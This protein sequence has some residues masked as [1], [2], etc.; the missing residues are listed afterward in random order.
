MISRKYYHLL[1]HAAC[2]L[3]FLIL[4]VIIFLNF[5]SLQTSLLRALLNGPL[6]IMVFY[7]NLLVLIP[8]FYE[9]KHYV[10]YILASFGLLFLFFTLRV[11]IRD[12]IIGSPQTVLMTERPLQSEFMI[13]TSFIFVFGLSIFYKLAINHLNAAERNREIL[14]QRDEAELRMLKAQVNPHF[15]FNTLNNLYSLAYTRSEKTAGAIMS[16]SEIMRYLIYEAGASLVP[17]EREIRFLTNYVE[18]EKL[19]IEDSSKVKLK[20]INPPEDHLIAP[21]IFIPFIENAFKHSGI[22]TDP[23]GFIQIFLDFHDNYIHLCCENTLASGLPKTSGGGT[24]LANARSRLELMY[25][26][27]YDLRIGQNHLIYVVNL[28]ITV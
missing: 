3:V 28:Q 26:G 14:R 23:E 11:L 20:I 5:W 7:G 17:V 19:R 24:G 25:H 27:K 16:L 4:S 13:V 6:F 15:L 9:K 8:L 10:T 2:W 1:L 12:H 21:L 18:L 22:D